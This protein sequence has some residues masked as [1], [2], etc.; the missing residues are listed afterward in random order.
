MAPVIWCRT[1]DG[2]TVMGVIGLSLLIILLNL[3]GYFLFLTHRRYPLTEGT[4]LKYHVVSFCLAMLLCGGLAFL[5]EDG[6]AAWIAAVSLHGIFSMSFLELWSVSQGSFFLSVMDRLEVWRGT[7]G[8]GV[9]FDVSSLAEIGRGKRISRLQAL[10]AKGWVRDDGR[11]LALTKTGRI[12][13][14]AFDVLRWVM[15]V[16][17]SG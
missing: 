14:H 5:A 9:P 15:H 7:E 17:A 6:F 2:D 1:R 4:V 8:E 16:R 10:L 11:V 12:V 3:V 13:S